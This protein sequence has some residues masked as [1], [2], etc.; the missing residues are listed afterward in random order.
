MRRRLIIAALAL[1]ALAGSAHAEERKKGGGETFIQLQTLTA[2]VIR[3]ST[4]AKVA[5]RSCGTR[6][7]AM[8]LRSSGEASG[9][10]VTLSPR[11]AALA[12]G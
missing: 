5:F 12:P 1:A 8:A 3:A 7:K 9:L 6:S 10:G 11:G 4:E 2:T